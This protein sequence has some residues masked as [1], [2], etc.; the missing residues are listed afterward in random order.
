[1]RT[2][3]NLQAVLIVIQLVQALALSLLALEV[4]RL[5]HDLDMQAL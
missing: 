5:R 4:A 1:M 3:Q 2:I